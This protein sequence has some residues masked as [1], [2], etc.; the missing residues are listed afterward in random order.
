MERLERNHFFCWK[1]TSF[2]QSLPFLHS[3]EHTICNSNTGKLI[4]QPILS[5]DVN[6]NFLSFCLKNKKNFFFFLI[7]IANSLHF[8][9]G[10]SLVLFFVCSSFSPFEKKEKSRLIRH[11]QMKPDIFFLFFRC[12][13]KQTLE[14]VKAYFWVLLPVVP[15]CNATG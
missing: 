9:L 15:Q 1:F 6:L 3:A 13:I 10:F 14:A 2:A 12:P 7:P 11:F 4:G 5:D 8:L